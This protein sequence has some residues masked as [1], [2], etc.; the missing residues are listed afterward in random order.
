MN[1]GLL[2]LVFL[3][4]SFI[5]FGKVKNLQ[6]V[7][8]DILKQ[9]YPQEWEALNSMHPIEENDL[10]PNNAVRKYVENREYLKFEDPELE[11]AGNAINRLTV[12]VLLP[13]T[14][15]YLLCVLALAVTSNA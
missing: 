1:F 7:L 4:L 5:V 13:L 2:S 3:V 8:L 14:L 12:R 11:A 6:T 10:F 9:R 15:L